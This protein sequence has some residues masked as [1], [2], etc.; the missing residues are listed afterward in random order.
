VNLVRCVPSPDHNDSREYIA[1]HPA[2][3]MAMRLSVSQAGKLNVKIS[4]SRA[5]YVLLQNSAVNNNS[6]TVTLRANSGQSSG[7]I[8]F[9]SEAR[10]L[11][12]GGM[13][14]SGTIPH[15]V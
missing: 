11:S 6:G 1:S 7:A 10:V 2:G 9:T 14:D 8:T 12:T 3:V 13:Y 5:Q 4:L 15:T